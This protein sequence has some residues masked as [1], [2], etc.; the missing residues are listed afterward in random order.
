MRQGRGGEKWENEK[1]RLEGA[2]A[3]MTD[4][5]ED[6]LAKEEACAKVERFNTF[7]EIPK[8]KMELHERNL[9]VG[10]ACEEEKVDKV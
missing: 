4:N 8:Q 5:L 1:E 7:M 2:T 3:R 10:K 9:A 6:M